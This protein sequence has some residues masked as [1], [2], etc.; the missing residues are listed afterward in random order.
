MEKIMSVL[1]TNDIK[2]IKK[3]LNKSFKLVIINRKIPNNS[4]IFFNQ[5]LKLS[6][7][8]SG[9]VQKKTAKDNIRNLLFEKLP[10]EI[11]KKIFY[12]DWVNDMA[13]LC[14]TFC[15]LEESKFVSFWL[16]TYRG[17]KRYHVDNVP[18]RLLVTYAGQGTEWLPNEVAD[19]RAYLNGEPNQNIVKDI[20]KKN[21]IEKWDIAIFK[22]GQ[23]GL[24]HRTPDTAL[25]DGN[26]ILMRLDHSRFWSNI[27][28][29]T[30]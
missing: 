27:Q 25:S 29:Q 2:D 26:S 24:L 18:Q 5:L 17:C 22:G 8:I 13:Q 30:A 15:D 12:K 11:Q 10:K 14:K 20:N 23:G 28:K 21:Y 19:I 7:T 1:Q 3:F 9:E 4:D 16:S 6:F